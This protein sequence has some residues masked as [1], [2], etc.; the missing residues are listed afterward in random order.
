MVGLGQPEYRAIVGGFAQARYVPPADP[1]DEQLRDLS[2]N[3]VSATDYYLGVRGTRIINLNNVTTLPSPERATVAGDRLTLAFDDLLDE[4]SVPAASA[5]TVK[6]GG[7]V[8]SLASANPVSVADDA[9]T[10]TLASAVGAS[11]VV[12][13]SYAKPASNP[14]TAPKRWPI[15]PGDKVES[16]SD[17]SVTNST[18]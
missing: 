5:F 15:L 11:D 8:V 9:V 16:F 6:V 4:N 10:L 17:W 2:G 13:V 12:T 18:P 7:S 3:P 14:L 1:T